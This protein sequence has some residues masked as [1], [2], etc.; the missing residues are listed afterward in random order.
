MK[1]LLVNPTSAN[2]YGA[3]GNRYPPLGLAYLAAV[4]RER[5][6]TVS[7]VDLDLE[8][9]HPVDFGMWDVVGIT[10]DTPRYPEALKV[11]KE[12]KKEGCIVIM[13]GYHVSFRDEEA[14]SSGLVDYVV[15]GEGDEVFPALLE[16]LD[17]GE[18]ED[19]AG[20]SFRR[21]GRFVRTQNP[22][23]PQDLDSLPL[24]ARDL[25]PMAKYRTNLR[26]RPSTSV[27]TSRGCPFN[28][29]FCASSAFGGL[30]WRPR[31]PS[32][33]AD[34][35]EMLYRDYGY[36]AITFM[37]DNF[38]LST[39]RVS[40]FIDELDRRGLDIYWYCF[41]RVDT[42]VRNPDLVRRMAEAGAVEIFLGLESGSQEVLNSYGKCTTVKQEKEAVE[43]LRSCGI[44]SYGSFMIGGIRETR[45]MVE[46]TIRLADELS[47]EAVQFSVLTPYPGTRLFEQARKERR[48][49]THLWRYYD[50]LHAV[51]R[52][53]FLS[54]LEVHNLISRA[55]RR[56]YLKA[57]TILKK[58]WKVLYRPQEVTSLVRG[59]IVAFQV[60]KSFKEY[61]LKLQSAFG[62]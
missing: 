35:V 58:V 36:R 55:Y 45:D 16:A 39:K 54:P 18:P 44:R 41:S 24:P 28:C 10:S 23:P 49:L 12:A 59:G 7:I 20:L 46:R 2:I 62:R 48:F 50:G 6:Y 5:G 26:G 38:T 61:R 57:K 17:E 43:I 40:E 4:T 47:L 27:I 22:L 9:E 11:A 42:I 56:V 51:M 13:G 19:V 52:L 8:P 34:E 31:S 1:V 60:G 29:H 32:S 53:D 33:V 21:N 30:R 15:R 3:L 37:D 14:L 25:L